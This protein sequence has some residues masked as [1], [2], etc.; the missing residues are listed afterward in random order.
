[1]AQG[2]QR[3]QKASKVEVEL[4]EVRGKTRCSCDSTRALKVK[5]TRGA[6]VRA[7]PAAASLPISDRPLS[8]D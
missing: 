5:P 7:M 8:P 2:F 6:L 4:V 3:F 1:M